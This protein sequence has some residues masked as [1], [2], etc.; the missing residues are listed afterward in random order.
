MVQGTISQSSSPSAA[1]SR[2][3][4]TLCGAISVLRRL[5]Q[6]Q[7]PA[8]SG[9]RSRRHRSPMIVSQA[10]AHAARPPAIALTAAAAMALPPRLPR[11]AM[12]GTPREF[13]DQRVFRFRRADK[14]HRYADDQRRSHRR[15]PVDHFRAGETMPSARCR[16]RRWHRS[17]HPPAPQTPRRNG[18]CRVMDGEACRFFVRHAAQAPEHH[19]PASSR[20]MIP[21]PTISTSQT[22]GRPFLHSSAVPHA[23]ASSDITRSSA[24]STMPQ[25]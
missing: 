21:L 2:L 19:R 6:R 17:C 11:T 23:A 12:K 8:G 16:W 20:R 1:R 7:M 10:L 18:S 9:N 5:R 3:S 14:P 25:A 22:M 15:Q 13:R 24:I 4:S